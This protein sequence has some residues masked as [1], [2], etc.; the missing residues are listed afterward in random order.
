MFSELLRES[1]LSLE[2][3]QS[4]CLVALAGG[5]T[6]A[7]KG[8]PA[9]Q[10]LFSRQIKELEE[11]FGTELISRKGRGIVLT[12]TGQRLHVIVRETFTALGD[13]KD[14]C[15]G[16]PVE[17]VI[18]AGESVIEWLLVPKLQEI[19]KRLPGVLFKF[20]NLSTS[21]SVKRLADGLIDFAVVRKDAVFRPLKHTPLGLMAY[22]L[23]VPVGLHKS[24]AP[25]R[26]DIKMLSGLPLATLEGEGTFRSTLTRAAKKE[27]VTLNIQVE[28]SS[29]PLAARAVATANLAA[30]LPRIAEVDLPHSAVE[31]VKIPFLKGLDRQICLASNARLIRIRPILGKVASELE[32]LCQF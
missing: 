5:V 27:N 16:Q 8:D 31:Q 1:G 21:E 6:S 29:F 17:V 18:G 22:S 10:S 24:N 32:R 23:F 26:G 11:F 4:F 20:L 19:R 9:R 12:A 13:F 14:H 25:T 7:A 3:L 2:R 30:I 28:C 15:K